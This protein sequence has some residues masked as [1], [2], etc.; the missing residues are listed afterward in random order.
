M[1]RFVIYASDGVWGVMTDQQAVD[2]V[3]HALRRAQE[4]DWVSARWLPRTSHC[5]GHAARCSAGTLHCGG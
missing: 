2:C 5:C 3:A 1:Y 4:T